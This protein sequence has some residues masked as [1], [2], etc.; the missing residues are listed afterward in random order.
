[1]NVSPLHLVRSQKCLESDE[2]TFG[3]LV[4]SSCL[5]GYDFTLLFE[6]SVLTTVP[7]II[8]CLLLVVRMCNLQ[9]RPSK[10]KRSWLYVAK[11]AT[12]LLYAVLHFIILAAMVIGSASKTPMSI[13]STAVIAVTFLFFLYASHLEHSRSLHPSTILSLYLGLS[14]VFD[15]IRV[16]TL[17][18]SFSS[19]IIA[20][21]LS[22]SVGL[23]AV[24]LVLEGTCKQPFLKK[25]YQDNTPEAVSGIYS[26]SLFLW[27]NPFLWKGYRGVLSVDTLN[28]LDDDLVS[29]SDPKALIESWNKNG[30]QFQPVL[31]YPD[32]SPG[33]GRICRQVS[34]SRAIDRFFLALQMEHSSGGDTSP[35]LHRLFLRAA[36]FGS[37]RV[38]LLIRGRRPEFAHR[39]LLS[40]RCLRHC[41]HRSCSACTRST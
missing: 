7:A 35:C 3:P 33:S 13:A 17:W 11:M 12:I 23:K 25:Q 9:G 1:M 38:G 30:K 8:A 36:F 40:D 10:V 41:I 4:H 28:V 5:G 31:N 32:R 37:A 29:A 14:L 27:V 39:G 18:L 21:V 2:A 15:V 19:P 20:S 34:A 26:R 22:A 24:M 6:E 16:R